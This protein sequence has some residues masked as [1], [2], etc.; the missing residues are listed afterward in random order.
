[1]G[2]GIPFS[3]PVYAEPSA[4]EN[5]E[6]VSEVEIAY[7]PQT[8]CVASA[9]L[10]R[11]DPPPDAA[12]GPVDVPARPTG[13]SHHRSTELSNGSTFGLP[14]RIMILQLLSFRML[15]TVCRCIL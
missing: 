4:F 13:G 6:I 9:S 5:V 15:L 7:K 2:V 8:T 10:G 1:M 12:P 11:P 14:L 3:P